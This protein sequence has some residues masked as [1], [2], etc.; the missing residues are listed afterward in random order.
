MSSIYDYKKYAILY[1]DDEKTSLDLFVEASSDRFRI[2]T[3]TDAEKGWELFQTH[4]DEIGIVISDQRMPGESGTELLAKIKKLRPRVLRILATAFSDMPAAIDA[5]N[6]GSVYKYIT[7][8]WNGPSMEVTLLR[9]LE[10]FMLQKERDQLA[11]ERFSS[12]HRL[13]ITD[14]V[15]SFG[16]IAAGMQHHIRNALVAVKTFLSLTPEKLKEEQIDMDNLHNPDFWNIFYRH[17]ESQIKRIT[18]LLTDIEDISPSMAFQYNDHVYL[19]VVINEVLESSKEECIA[20]NIQFE[21]NIPDTLPA[22]TVD[23]QKFHRI[24][25]LLMKDEIITLPSGS[26]LEFKAELFEKEEDSKSWIKVMISDNGPPLSTDALRSIFDPFFVR[27]GSVQDF[28]LYLMGCFFLVYHHGGTMR[29]ESDPK[30]GNTFILEF[31]TKTVLP[32]QHSISQ[33]FMD[34]VLLNEE[35]WEKLLSEI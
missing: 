28:G 4:Q 17:A 22:L 2:L 16:L 15:I 7:K 21:N 9:G 1:V 3:A 8:P 20:K 30:T 29:A 10:F 35:L 13:M 32:P 24:F 11:R 33:E 18:D 25:E 12:L 6:N 19:K 23:R 31:P 27:N 26:F 5:I 34:Q 14:R